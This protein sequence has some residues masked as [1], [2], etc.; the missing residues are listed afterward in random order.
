MYMWA[1]MWRCLS[2]EPEAGY[3]SSTQIY[4]YI[5]MYVCVYIYIY[6]YTHI[7]FFTPEVGRLAEKPELVHLHYKPEF[8]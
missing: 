3:P 2:Y 7:N 4:I 1:P 5:Y 8:G 6:V